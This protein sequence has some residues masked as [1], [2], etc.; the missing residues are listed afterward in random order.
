[1]SGKKSVI[2]KIYQR[3][4]LFLTLVAVSAA[5]TISCKS[6]SG[7]VDERK[8]I[9]SSFL[10]AHSAF[11]NTNKAQDEFFTQYF[12][13]LELIEWDSSAVANTPN[14]DSLLTSAREANDERK[15]LVNE[16]PA[17][18]DSAILF[19]DRANALINIMDSTY[20]NEFAQ[21][22]K[23]MEVKSAGRYPQIQ[24]LMAT[25]IGKIRKAQSDYQLAT[26]SMTKKYQV[27]V[28]N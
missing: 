20:R 1:L 11:K 4:Y 21:A 15:K 10:A 25:P 19:H 3:Q 8:K 12:K 16:E 24:Q 22:I 23:I 18:Q 2:M 5:I 27:V 17:A 13:Q 28:A 7:P 6:G 9:V 26:E 14:L